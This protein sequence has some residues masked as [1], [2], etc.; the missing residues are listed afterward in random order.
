MFRATIFRLVTHFLLE[1]PAAKRSFDE[2]AEDL[3]ARL[4][5]LEQ[6]CVTAADT[7]ANR[8]QLAHI[9]GIER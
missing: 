5:A 4:P 1:R 3:Q 8:D 6:R 2:L 7:P 9:I